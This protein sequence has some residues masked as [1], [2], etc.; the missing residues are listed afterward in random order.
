MPRIPRSPGRRCSVFFDVRDASL[1]ELFATFRLL[2]GL[3]LVATRPAVVATGAAT[4]T[5]RDGHL[6]TVDGTTGQVDVV[7]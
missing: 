3:S 1:R 6:V 5:L 2:T 4:S 7:G